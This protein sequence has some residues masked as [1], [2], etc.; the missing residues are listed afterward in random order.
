MIE[1]LYAINKR[2]LSGL[3]KSQESFTRFYDRSN[4]FECMYIRKDNSLFSTN[5]SLLCMNNNMQHKWEKPH[6]FIVDLLLRKQS[7][8]LC[9]SYQWEF[10]FHLFQ[11]RWQK[12]RLFY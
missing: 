3:F 11:H 7:L 4:D 10:V 8:F 5:S 6:L 12:R 2:I 9:S 1:L